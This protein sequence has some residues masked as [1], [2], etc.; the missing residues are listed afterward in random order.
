MVAQSAL[1]AEAEEYPSAPEKVQEARLCR[2]RSTSTGDG[3]G[4]GSGAGDAKTAVAP[5]RAA[6]AREEVY[7]INT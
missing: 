6:A 1:L 5:R 4:V 7:M 2:L 3:P